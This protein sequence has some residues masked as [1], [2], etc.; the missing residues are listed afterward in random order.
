MKKILIFSII[1]LLL[2][3]V[4]IRVLLVVV[5][6]RRFTAD[7]TYHMAP[8]YFAEYEYYEDGYYY[9]FSPAS[10]FN[11]DCFARVCTVDS[12]ELNMNSSGELTTN[13]MSISLFIWPHWDKSYEMG[14]HME[15]YDAEHSINV[16]FYIDSELNYIDYSDGENEGVDAEKQL[17][18]EYYDEIEE[19]VNRA[20]EKWNVV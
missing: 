4:L 1:S 13:G 16:Q 18:E 17:L 5:L 9:Y 11:M 3:A 12:M 6:N 10:I 2:F 14:L 8:N 20:K 15:Q 19:L 7:M